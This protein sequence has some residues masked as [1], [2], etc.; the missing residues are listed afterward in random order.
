MPQLDFVILFNTFIS[1]IFFFI[2][3]YVVF[4]VFLLPEEFSL[5]VG[6]VFALNKIN[7]EEKKAYVFKNNTKKVFSILKKLNLYIYTI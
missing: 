5:M 4:I 7:V 6:R 1:L 3:F 2:I